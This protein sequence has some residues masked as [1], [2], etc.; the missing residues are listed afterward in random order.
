MASG[1][2]MLVFFALLGAGIKTIDEAYDRG[3][4]SRRVAY[5]LAPFLVALWFVL[6]FQ[7]K[8]AATLLSAI[9]VSS[10]LAGKLDNTVFKLSAAVLLAA[11]LIK[12]VSIALLPF[13][14]LVV[15]GVIDELADG[16]ADKHRKTRRG[17]LLRRRFGMKLGVLL[18]FVFSQLELVYALALL[19]F[20][21]AYDSVSIALPQGANVPAG[22]K[23]YES[24]I[25]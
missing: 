19:A 23:V 16:Y 8:N 2:G 11:M 18:L 9:L 13:L 5:L 15:L 1:Y 24:H 10:L 25:L 6:S 3:A 22:V 4:P 12:G 14:F 20:D 21:L 7:D 17:F